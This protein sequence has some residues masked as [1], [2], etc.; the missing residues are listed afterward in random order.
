[1]H[2]QLHIITDVS[3]MYNKVK[4]FKLYGILTQSVDMILLTHIFNIQK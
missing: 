4:W 2:F 3:V 1:M